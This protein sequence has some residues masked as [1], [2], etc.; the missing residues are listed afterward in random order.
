MGGGIGIRHNKKES[1]GKY[2]SLLSAIFPLLLSPYFLCFSP[3][4]KLIRIL[5]VVGQV[6]P[7][8]LPLEWQHKEVS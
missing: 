7:L 8:T 3:A 1:I 6:F 5:Y 2:Y 4:S